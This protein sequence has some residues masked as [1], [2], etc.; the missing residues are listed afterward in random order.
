MSVRLAEYT[1]DLLRAIKLLRP[2]N[3]QTRRAIAALL[4]AEWTD[5][6]FSARV[7]DKIE[8]GPEVIP[9]IPIS[10]SYRT[11][12]KVQQSPP[13]SHEKE[14]ETA[15]KLEPAVTIEGI[16][17]TLT[18][19]GSTPTRLP[20]WLDKATP[21]PKPTPADIPELPAPEP[22][23]QPIWTRSIL[24]ST[25]E[26][27]T[28]EGPFDHYTVV[29]TLAQGKVV[30]KM[31]RLALPMLA[32][33]VQLLVD[34]SDGMLPFLTDINGIMRHF[35]EV[36]GE[37]RLTILRFANCPLRGAGK[38]HLRTWS[39]YISEH[40]P[41]PM[42]RVVSI[43]DLGIGNPPAGDPPASPIEWLDFA[44]HLQ[45][46]NC[47]LL[48]LI[49]YGPSRWPEAIKKEIPVVHWDPATGVGQIVRLIR[50]F[51]RWR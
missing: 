28:D 1:A 46:A 51:Y 16:P 32:G 9:D 30:S 47:S 2:E 27:M 34:R 50:Q 36:V 23:F 41:P 37:D 18:P 44:R 33:N 21:L 3:E 25:L 14:P 35:R 49:P 22:L 17:S 42:T 6:V 24:T 43:T 5:T 40:T 38:G 19:Y 13:K 20:V 48:V 12:E 26:V 29:R 15:A 45:R 7:K 39:N 11:T 4:G 8:P 31:P 10:T